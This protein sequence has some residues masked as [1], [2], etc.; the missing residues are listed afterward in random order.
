LGRNVDDLRLEEEF[1][2]ALEEKPDFILRFSKMIEAKK[3]YWKNET[4][5]LTLFDI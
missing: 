2:K 5:L 4:F 3:L 1:I